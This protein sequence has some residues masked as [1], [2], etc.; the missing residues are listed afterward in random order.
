[1]SDNARIHDIDTTTEELNHPQ[2]DATGSAAAEQAVL[3]HGASVS[4]AK[5]DEDGDAQR[6]DGAPVP[7]SRGEIN[8]GHS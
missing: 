6:T 2:D 7:N 5:H 1:M 4:A 3:T 8:R